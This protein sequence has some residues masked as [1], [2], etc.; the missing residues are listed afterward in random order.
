[1]VGVAV[2]VT[3][4]PLLKFPEHVAP[5]SIPAG[6]L[7]SEPLPVLETFK[8]KLDGAKVAVTVLAALSVTLQVVPE[9]VVH[10]L[11]PVKR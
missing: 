6:V 3:L 4:E 9:L 1:M 8:A 11:Q 5:Q 2:K 10:P 7:T